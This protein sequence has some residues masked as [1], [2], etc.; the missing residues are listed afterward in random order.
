M[1][2]IFF[3]WK[4]AIIL[5]FTVSSVKFGFYHVLW[6]CWFGKQDKRYIWREALQ[7]W[8]YIYFSFWLL[9]CTLPV[10]KKIFRYKSLPKGTVF[11]FFLQFCIFLIYLYDLSGEYMLQW[12]S[13]VQFIVNVLPIYCFCKVVFD[14]TIF[15]LII[16]TFSNPFFFIQ[17]VQQMFGPVLQWLWSYVSLFV[18]M[19]LYSLWGRSLCPF[20]L[21]KAGLGINYPLLLFFKHILTVVQC[22]IFWPCIY[23]WKLSHFLCY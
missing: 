21:K 15:I 20:L 18:I 11:L 10:E 8:R 3:F 9:L 7:E 19:L 6:Q 13:P 22:I 14:N 12:Y 1:V 5:L 16:V 23:T 2:F 17:Q 4:T